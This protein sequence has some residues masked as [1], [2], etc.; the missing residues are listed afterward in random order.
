MDGTLLTTLTS[1]ADGMYT[2]QLPTWPAF[3]PH[4]FVAKASSK[5]FLTDSSEVLKVNLPFQVATTTLQSGYQGLDGDFHQARSLN[6]FMYGMS[7]PGATIRI[8]CNG[9]AFYTIRAEADGHWAGLT[10]HLDDGDYIFTAT[11]TNNLGS[12][13]TTEPWKVH[14]DSVA[15]VAPTI[16]LD[17]GAG[18]VLSTDRPH[19]SGTAEPNTVL[20]IYLDGKEQVRTVVGR[21][22]N[23]A[24]WFDLPVGNYQVTAQSM[25]LVF[26]KSPFTAPLAFSVSAASELAADNSTAGR[27]DVGS[28]VQGMLEKVGDHDWFRVKLDALTLYQFTFKGLESHAGTLDTAGYEVFEPYLRLWEEVAPGQF[29]NAGLTESAPLGAPVTIKFTPTRSGE[30]YL[31]MGS[32]YLRGSYTLSA[33]VLQYDDHGDNTSNATP[34]PVNG[35]LNGKIDYGTDTDMFALSLQ[36]GVS[37]TVKLDRGTAAPDQLQRYLYFTPDTWVSTHSYTSDG[38]SFVTLLPYKDGQYF[39]SASSLPGAT[40]AYHIALTLAPDDY[41]ASVATTG[42]V[43]ASAPAQGKLEVLG[44]A[45]WF[46]ATLTAGQSY[47]MRAQ[48]SNG[49]KLDLHFFDA[50]GQPAGFDNSIV[51]GQ[52]AQLWKATASGDYYFQVSSFSETGAYT[53]TVA[54]AAP[55]DFSAD[56]STTGQLAAAARASGTLEVPG[57]VDWFKLS[58]EAGTDYIFRLEGGN[59]DPS[60]ITAAR[61]QLR[62]AGG[63]L[64]AQRTDWGYD[65]TSQ[66]VFHASQTG[67][68]YLALD[69]P[70]YARTA[71]YTISMAANRQDTVA[72]DTS[73]TASLSPGQVKLGNIDFATDADWYRVD[74]QAGHQYNFELTGTT[75][76]GGTLPSNMMQLALVD[77][78]G[79]VIA[80]PSPLYGKDPVLNYHAS[81]ATTLYLRVAQQ[82]NST[83]SYTLKA[84]LDYNAFVDTLPP[85]YKFLEGVSA[86]RI[87]ERGTALYLNFD[88]TLSLA[89]G[90]ATLRLASGELVEEFSGTKGNASVESG[91][92]TL[93]LR[94]SALAYDTD[95]VLTL[96][97]GSVADTS[98]HLFEGTTIKFRTPA[99]PARQDGSAANETFRSP[100]GNQIIDG[101][102]GID[103]V[104][105]PGTASDYLIRKT[106]EVLKIDGWFLPQGLH[107]LLGIERVQFDDR[108]M[109]F[110]IDGNAG[111]AYR[112][113][114]AA[115]A[116]SPD[117]GGLGFWIKAMDQGVSLAEVSTAFVQSDEFKTLYSGASGNRAIL[118]KMYDNVLHRA[119]DAGGLNWYLNLLD[120]KVITVAQALADISESA[121]NKAAL[122]GVMQ[123]GFD[124]TPYG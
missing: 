62:D 39:I 119:P 41:L 53:L 113:Y 100:V 97:A 81:S 42:R 56:T 5:D 20:M 38:A 25:D 87:L 90:A 118:E 82:D 57:D 31:D 29:V 69:D 106:G 19:F 115:F 34:L 91:M 123:N 95:Y 59:A 104:I 73:T 120:T 21:D 79:T 11:A 70:M 114:Q 72:G 98:K 36:A 55:D 48:T 66:L 49:T 99:S 23:W 101:K 76:R 63:K 86:G 30:Y 109:A 52:N 32:A 117:K 46:K 47:L 74:M 102:G 9:Q 94:P 107:T 110:D 58:L 1:G 67:T 77:S 50:Y 17:N 61:L 6:F 40:P 75:G 111:Q 71:S 16:M 27:L 14:I 68:Y 8:Q 45:D 93:T 15:P 22:G 65:A 80:S 4:E 51:S 24:A 103:T 84:S 112:I 33:S 108:S 96:A 54:P 43:L 121:E 3:G 60:L 44:D 7:T 105:M 28:S 13:S 35:Q 124:Y 26:Q 10:P 12:T 85:L 2:Y 64:L 89:S 88:E 18:N 78:S 37:Y 92:A 116:R 83:G 122:I